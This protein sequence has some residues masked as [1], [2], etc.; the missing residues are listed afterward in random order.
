M[1]T[2]YILLKYLHVLLAIIAIGFNATYAIWIARAARQPEHLSYTLRGIKFLDDRFANPC[3]ALL[4]VTGL[5]MVAT[6][7]WPLTTLWIDAALVLYIGILILGLGFY[8]PALR[9]QI[10][11]L[12]T[13]GS[14]SPEY[15]STAR[16]STIVGIATLI[17]V[18]LIVFLMVVKPG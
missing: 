4:L 15:Q 18:L 17:L 14:G 13:H 12:Q 5:A 11:E 3:Y 6:G 16:R 8:T 10:A 1:N 7:G 9:R 2:V